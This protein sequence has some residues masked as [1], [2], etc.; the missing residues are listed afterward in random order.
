ML[1]EPFLYHGR[2]SDH[3]GVRP[4]LQ[5]MP[6]IGRFFPLLEEEMRALGDDVDKII[7]RGI[8]GAVQD[9]AT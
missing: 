6:F 2:R 4:E 1:E 8:A 9:K 7:S 5:Q 3:F